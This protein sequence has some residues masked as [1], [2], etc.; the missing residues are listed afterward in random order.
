MKHGSSYCLS[1]C[2]ICLS[3]K[4][5]I[6]ILS[7]FIPFT[8]REIIK[9]M[10]ILCNQENIN[11]HFGTDRMDLFTCIKLPH[12]NRKAEVTHDFDA[13]LP[14]VHTRDLIPFKSI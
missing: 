7:K 10:N 8:I 14:F 4:Q 2:A 12:G 5:F 6:L 13:V 9:F 11:R 1:G 3:L